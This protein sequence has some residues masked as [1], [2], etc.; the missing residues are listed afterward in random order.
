MTWVKRILLSHWYWGALTLMGLLIVSLMV[1]SP[2]IPNNINVS[3]GELAHETVISQRYIEF[4]SHKDRE[5]TEKLRQD[6]MRLI[7]PV[8]SVNPEL[9]KESL[10]HVTQFFTLF[11]SYQDQ[12]KEAPVDVLDDLLFLGSN[13]AR[14]VLI[15]AERIDVL[16]TTIKSIMTDLLEAGIRQVNY[17]QIKTDVLARKELLGGLDIDSKN[18]SVEVVK[19]FLI[20]NMTLDEA[21]T[22]LLINSEMKLVK[23][24][25][26]IYKE[27]QPIIYKGELVEPHH[28]EVLMELGKYGGQINI[29]QYVG[30]LLMTFFLFL[31]LERFIYFFSPQIYKKPKFFILMFVTL[32]LILGV[33]RLFQSV[34][35]LSPVFQLEYLVPIPIAAM[36]LS[37]LVTPN[38]SLITGTIFSVFLTLMFSE[39]LSIFFYFFMC[40]AVTTFAMYRRYKRVDLIASGYVV[41]VFNAVFILAIG[42]FQV[43]ESYSLLW[44][45]SN[46]FMGLVNGIV[47]AMFSLALLPYFESVFKI[48]TSQ[49]LLELSNLSHP[50]LKQ[51]MMTAPG[52]YQHS[53]MVANLAEAGA[54]AIK[55][56]VVLCRTG[57]Y[58]HDIG[59]IKRPI[60]FTENQ[61]SSE[62]PHDKLT[63]RMSKMIIVSH[64]KDGVEMAADHKLPLVIRKII[65]EHHGTTQVSFF[66]KQAQLEEEKTVV[67]EVDFR[68]PG[69]KP[70]F[71]ESGIVMLADSVE[72][73]TRSMKEPSLSKI[74]GLVEDIFK[75]KISD[76][77]L[78][79][80]GLSL[81]EIDKIKNSFLMIFRS[82]YHSRLN[83]QDEIDSMLNQRSDS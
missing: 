41:G 69:P 28:I 62:N 73:A 78:D 26:T 70:S 49:T 19:K 30:I 80:S 7:E 32:I 4:E 14:Y 59:K 24:F 2:H 79:E 42:L 13:L 17:K 34:S 37:F 43:Q 75:M 76:N 40:S 53:L 57:S 50:L 46:M 71:K 22:N 33:T 67:D 66:F 39:D 47:S 23:P 82:V 35:F 52:T 74:E 11:R 9:T 31:L 58:F 61:F 83:Y 48:T 10:V 65:E 72:A 5:K 15:D 55:A 12:I 51:L 29:K 56:D 64:S 25:T 60:F 63:P 45:V 20:P 3:E 21:Q 18:F 16:E 38:I 68:Y 36:I 44:F 1:F 8:Y 6:R 81:L 77:Q 27:G 54:E